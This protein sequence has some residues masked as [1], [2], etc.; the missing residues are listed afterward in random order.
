MFF[1]AIFRRVARGLSCARWRTCAPSSVCRISRFDSQVVGS[2]LVIVD[3]NLSPVRF[4]NSSPDART[5]WLRDEGR[6]LS[7]HLSHLRTRSSQR[8]RR[9]QLGAFPSGSN[10]SRWQ[11]RCV[12]PFK[13]RQPPTAKH[14]VHSVRNT[15]SRMFLSSP[16][17]NSTG[18]LREA[19]SRPGFRFAKRGRTRRNGSGDQRRRRGRTG[20]G[21]S[22]FGTRRRERRCSGYLR[23][24]CA[25]LFFSRGGCS[26]PLQCVFA[27]SPRNPAL[28]CRRRSGW[29]RRA[30]VRTDSAC[31]RTS[32]SVHA[33]DC[34]TLLSAGVRCIVLTLG[35]LGV[36][37]AQQG[38]GRE[39]PS[40]EVS[41]T[42]LAA[43]PAKVVRKV[44]ARGE[45]S[46][47]ALV[48]V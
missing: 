31:A 42:H 27:P 1:I 46:R 38:S 41:Y 21:A 43:P 9:R 19:G 37:V 14:A 30:A 22:S 25:G 5:C 2:R 18:P 32:V 48:L 45:T 10:P 24:A 33:G 39:T 26:E 6:L 40:G 3:A 13:S 17:V 34:S 44:G 7:H 11:R 16:S 29:P 23:V 4:R 8:A 28:C 36:I 47:A 12:H 20:A 15:E 35:G